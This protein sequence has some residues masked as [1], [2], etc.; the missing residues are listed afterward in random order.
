MKKTIVIIPAH[1]EEKNVA[2][3]V[4]GVKETLAASDVIV[5]NDC[6][7]DNTSEV[8]RLAGA[9]V[10]DLPIK[11]NYGATIQ[12]GFKYALRN[13]YGAIVLLDGDGQHNPQY[14]PQMIQHITEDPY[15]LIIGSRFVGKM[16]Y[17]MPI[18]RR[19]GS[20][21]F[22]WL[23]LLLS[24][25]RIYDPTSGYQVFNRRVAKLYVS[26]HFPDDYPDADVILMLLLHKVR[27][28]E[29]A[30]E[31]RQSSGPSM[32]TKLSSLY[33]PL[34]MLVSVSITASRWQTLRKRG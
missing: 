33:Y 15:D 2:S 11:L 22:S 12:T 10:I 5:I 30:M 26:S 9:S 19:V 16:G 4:R 8:A 31:M 6:S 32:H 7:S 34:K 29:L 24:G 14:I 13:G 21:F 23:I 27:I 1:N 18:M 20:L 3:V 25:R 17:R 28:H